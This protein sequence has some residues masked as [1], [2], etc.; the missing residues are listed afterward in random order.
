MNILSLHRLS[1]SHIES[2]KKAAP[3]AVVNVSE[4]K[5]CAAYL[6]DVDILLAFGQT[7]LAPILPK[8]PRLRWVHA[9]TAGV[10][11]F[12][13]L[14]DFKNS[15]ILLTNVRGIHGIPI[16]E[17]VLGMMLGFSRGLFEARESQKSHLWK[18]IHGLDE[19]FGRTAA[20]IGMGSVG[21]AIAERLRA[22]GMKIL[23]IKREI[24]K[25]PRADEVFPMAGLDEVL[26]RA[27][28]VIVT[29]PLTDETRG[30][31]S[32]RTF[33]KMKKS[34]FFVNVSRGPVVDEDDLSA[35]LN[36]EVIRGAGLDVFCEEPLSPD[37]SL[38]DAKNI[39]ITP[40]RAATS[41]YYMDRAIG[42]FV[43]NLAAFP[44]RTKMI[45][46][47]EKSRGY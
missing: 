23:A 21:G 25:D 27:D 24:S 2:I 15:D 36:G 26:S 31:F 1:K 33:A 10:D 13:A 12:L 29:L 42:V 16:A 9:L 45:N 34:A 28:Y 6:P 22:M 40:H 8:A 17:H 20:I 19:I 4:A 7:N 5:E 44:D 11:G 14:D 41:P 35:A 30:L 38:W 37:S 39:I 18:S 43:E 3:G 47:I 46:V 32:A